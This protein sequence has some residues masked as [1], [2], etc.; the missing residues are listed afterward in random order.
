MN[1]LTSLGTVS[2]NIAGQSYMVS[3]NVGTYPDGS[4]LINLTKVDT[5][6]VIAVISEYRFGSTELPQHSF[7]GEHWCATTGVTKQL[8]DLE[9]LAELQTVKYLD[10]Y[11]LTQTALVI[12]AA[13]QLPDLNK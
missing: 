13:A 7:F 12:L 5:K 8:V 3:V 11:T 6:E 10:V 2:I 9:V 4:T 1:K